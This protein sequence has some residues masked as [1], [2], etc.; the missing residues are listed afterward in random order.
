MFDSLSSRLSTVFSGLR[1]KGR[2][3]DSDIDATVREIRV[4]LLDADVALPVV[5]AFTGA[6]RQRAHGAEVNKALNPAQQVVKIVN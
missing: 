2:L 3:S 4:A 5:K 1:S 6:V